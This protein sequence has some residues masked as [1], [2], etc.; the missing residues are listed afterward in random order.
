MQ[1]LF[2]KTNIKWKIVKVRKNEH[3]NRA[4]LSPEACTSAANISRVLRGSQSYN[5]VRVLRIGLVVFEYFWRVYR[6]W[7]SFIIFVCGCLK[8][9][10]LREPS[11]VSTIIGIMPKLEAFFIICHIQNERERE[12]K[13]DLR[14][15][16][17]KI[18]HWFLC[19]W[20]LSLFA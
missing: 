11:S 20:Y 3:W 4:M 19:L 1:P 17:P 2:C 16:G 12:R 9:N 18:F 8:M 10:E 14:R 5:I 7:E 13:R 6:A 15:G